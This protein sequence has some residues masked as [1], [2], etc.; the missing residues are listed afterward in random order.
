MTKATDNV[1]LVLPREIRATQDEHP[2]RLERIE[3][4]M[5]EVH[6]GML[7]GLG[8]AAHANVRHEMVEKRLDD[9]TQRVERLEKQH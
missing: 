9:L 7:T 1:V 4:R 5:G 2:R 8:L 3:K 6:E